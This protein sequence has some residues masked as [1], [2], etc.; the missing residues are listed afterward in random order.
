M[1]Q[2]FLG[3]WFRLQDLFYL[4]LIGLFGQWECEH[5]GCDFASS[6][7]QVSSAI[8]GLGEETFQFAQEIP[9][10]YRVFP[11]NY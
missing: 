11:C 4:L 2:E 6:Q 8:S 10:F 7:E 3:T 5:Y 9:V 1:S